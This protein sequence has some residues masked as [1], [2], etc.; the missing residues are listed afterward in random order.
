MT[1]KQVK[2]NSGISHDAAVIALNNFHDEHHYF[3]MTLCDQ[4]SMAQNKLVNVWYKDIAEQMDDT[5]LNIRRQ[6]KLNYGVPL[7]RAKSE[8]LDWLYSQT[9]DK[10]R[11][12]KRLIAMDGFDITS[13]DEM[14]SD[15][16]GQYINAMHEDHPYL[17]VVKKKAARV[18]AIERVE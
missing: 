7:L 2:V 12:E 14:D 16:M 13:N 15:L 3:Y 10:L 1:T 9:I 11:Y 4:R 18:A 6:C 17:E 8:M 5:F